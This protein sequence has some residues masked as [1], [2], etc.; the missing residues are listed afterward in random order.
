MDL[1][2]GKVVRLAQGNFTRET[3]Y[4]TDPEAIAR[5]F[6]AAGATHLHVVDL[7][8]AR[9][10]ALR[11]REL[12][13]RVVRATALRV[14]V[15]GGVRTLAD[16]R[17]LLA[18]GVE[19]VVIGSLAVTDQAATAAI[20]GAVG[21]ERIT[22]ALDVTLAGDGGPLVAIRGW[23]ETSTLT[24]DD[25]L[26]RYPG[27]S[28]MLCTDIARDGMLAGPNVALYRALV[29]RHPG[30][31]I[32]ASGGVSSLADLRELASAGV[33]SAI[34]GRALYERKLTLAEALAC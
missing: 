7:D 2:G 25:V 19:R 20:V 5:E 8:G 11:Q 1:A 23:Q 30:I 16:V 32:V 3:V 24:L 14:Q 17:E 4:A 10:P 33:P 12:I 21:S 15:G 28:R 29:A 9:D 18:L 31:E 34:V 27:V 13:A 22:L 6:A 26:A